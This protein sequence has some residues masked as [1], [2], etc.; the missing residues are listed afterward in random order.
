[1]KQAQGKLMKTKQR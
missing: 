1:M